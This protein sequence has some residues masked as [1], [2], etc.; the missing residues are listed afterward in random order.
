MKYK[1]QFF[2]GSLFVAFFYFLLIGIVCAEEVLKSSDG[3]INYRSMAIIGGKMVSQ[4]KVD[5]VIEL[6]ERYADAS[7]NHNSHL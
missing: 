3:K 2:V 4:G 7:N 1:S 6:L 5:K